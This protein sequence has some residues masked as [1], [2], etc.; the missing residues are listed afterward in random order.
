MSTTKARPKILV[1]PLNWGLGHA[2]RCIPVIKELINQ[3]AKVI[4]AS[5]G[6]SYELLRSEFPELKLYRLTPYDVMYSSDSMI[7]NIAAQLPKILLAIYKE[8][9]SFA[10]IIQQEKIDGI[11]S[12]NRFGCYHSSVYSV[13]ITHQLNIKIPLKPVEMFTRMVNRKII[14]RYDECWI[15]DYAGKDNISGEL[16]KPEKIKNAKFIGTL[17]RFEARTLPKKYD[18]LAIL[19]GPEPQRSN[20]EKLVLEQLKEL[21]L[22]CAVV[23]GKT[24]VVERISDVNLDIFSHCSVPAL[25]DLIA[26]S[27]VVIARS[28][29]STIMDLIQMK[30]RALLIPTPGQTEQEYLAEKLQK[31]AWFMSQ[32]QKNLDVAKAIEQIPEFDADLF[33]KY[34]DDNILS[35]TISAFLKNCEIKNKKLIKK[36]KT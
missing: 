31:R 36:I 25:N 1:A 21:P 17:S 24:E 15:P 22:K 29:Y 34:K 27:D 3:D 20:F 8:H 28:G 19:S 12:D 26:S 35:E 4:L 33:E 14:D 9:K 16:S 23:Q 30:K 5:D 13:Y 11:I 6:R 7:F 18:I 2:T 32:E 10:R